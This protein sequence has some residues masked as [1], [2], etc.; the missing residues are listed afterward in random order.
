MTH[1]RLRI[2]RPEAVRGDCRDRKHRWP[3]AHIAG[4]D[5]LGVIAALVSRLLIGI[6]GGTGNLRRRVLVQEIF[7]SVWQSSRRRTCPVDGSLES[8]MDSPRC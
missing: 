3:P 2:A 5:G 8:V 7:T 6:A 1:A 4:P